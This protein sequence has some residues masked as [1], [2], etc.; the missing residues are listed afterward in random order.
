MLR[1]HYFCVWLQVAP[2]LAASRLVGD[3]SRPLLMAPDPEVVLI[4]LAEERSELYRATAHVGIPV[5]SG[6][7]PLTL[8]REILD[9]A[10]VD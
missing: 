8:A 1:R 9:R 3:T 4:R 5:V 7:T 2:E 6:V 10:T